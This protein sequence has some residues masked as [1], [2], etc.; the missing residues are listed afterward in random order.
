M[1]SPSVNSVS[2]WRQIASQIQ[3]S[4]KFVFVS[5]IWNR[6]GQIASSLNKRY[7]NIN[8]HNL[9]GNCMR[10]PKIQS[11]L[12]STCELPFGSC[13]GH[14]VSDLSRHPKKEKLNDPLLVRFS[15]KYFIFTLI[16]SCS[17]LKLYFK[18]DFCLNSAAHL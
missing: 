7:G 2:T 11:L 18:R 16:H 12:D 8:V 13:R 4:H 1:N 10:T 6:N 17:S 9:G 15:L 5:S 14:S 3:G